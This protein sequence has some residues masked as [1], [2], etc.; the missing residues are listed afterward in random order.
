MS[1]VQAEGHSHQLTA[2]AYIYPN[3]LFHNIVS[4]LLDNDANRC[5]LIGQFADKYLQ[6]DDV[7]FYWL[8]NIA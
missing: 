2:K 8:K 3:N 7:R 5:D 1:L 4:H 6:F